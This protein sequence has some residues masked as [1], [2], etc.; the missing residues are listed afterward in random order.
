[1][2]GASSKIRDQHGN[3]L[4]ADGFSP[5]IFGHHQ[6]G[7][8]ADKPTPTFSLRGVLGLNQSVELNRQTES[9]KKETVFFVNHLEKEL[10]QLH[11]QNDQALKK[12]IEELTH[13]IKNLSTAVKDLKQVDQ[14]IIQ[15]APEPSQYQINFL[16]R[17]RQFIIN[18][19]K[20]I[21]SASEWVQV[22]RK[23]KNKKNAFWGNVRNK[24]TG[25]EQ[26]LFSN[27]HSAAR[28]AA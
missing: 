4:K 8:V 12:E 14:A 9:I 18:I 24:K 7:Q 17:L 11:Q 16:G 2:A 5:E 13:A 25:G 28:S 19:T 27:E 20:D 26:Y 3:L 6:S 1:M 22:L 21:T 23:R 10:N 15:S